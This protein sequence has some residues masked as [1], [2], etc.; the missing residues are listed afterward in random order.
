MNKI[1]IE[2]KKKL[3]FSNRNETVRFR[4]YELIVRVAGSSTRAFELGENSALL[5]G[6]MNEV[7]STDT[8]VALNA[9]EILRQVME[10]LDILI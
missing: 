9:I 10:K 7:A 6:F 8:L 5:D 2:R 4:V 3:I 1:I